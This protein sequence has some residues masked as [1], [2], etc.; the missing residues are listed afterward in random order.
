MNTCKYITYSYYKALKADFQ[1]MLDSVLSQLP[2]DILIVRLICWC[3]PSDNEEYEQWLSHSKRRLREYF[4]DCVPSFNL[5]AQ[6]PLDSGLVL[7]VHALQP[8][9]QDVV[10]YKKFQKHP[11][12]VVENRLGRFLFASGF[13]GSGLLVSATLQAR[14]A[15][16]QLANLLESEGFLPSDIVRQWNY[17]ERITEMDA[18]G[19]RYQSF[20]N[21]RADYYESAKWGN[22]Y[23]AATGIGAA[24]GGICIDVDAVI[25]VNDSCRILPVDN[26]LQIAAHA[27]SSDVIVA[28]GHQKKSPKFERAKMLRLNQLKFIYIS[29]TAAIRGEESLAG[30]GIERQID[31]TVENIAQLTQGL[32]IRHIRVYLKNPSD[33]Q[34]ACRLLALKYPHVPVSFFWA[35]VCR[36]SLLIEIEGVA[37][38]INS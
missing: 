2:T 17:I 5:V 22:G 27:Y 36:D 37:S 26:S 30:V 34:V 9:N 38:E 35:D 6:P 1:V 31:V 29:G 16:S 11:Y 19:Q 13:H 12:V 4:T 7:E 3:A 10:Y 18:D 20:N 15:F 23:P 21:A 32:P 24:F 8:S 33:Y 28:S 14:E 25:G